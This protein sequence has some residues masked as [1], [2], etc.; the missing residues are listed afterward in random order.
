MKRRFWLGL[1]LAA[2][3]VH[4]EEVAKLVPYPEGYREWRF[5]G[6]I[7]SHPEERTDAP[8]GLIHHLYGNDQALEGLRTGIFPAGAVLVADW[9]LLKEKYSGSFDEGARD[10]TDVM[11]K[12]ARFAA[13]GGWGYDQFAGDSREIRRI[14]GAEPNQCSK[15]HT[16]VR[17][18]DYVFTSL[19]P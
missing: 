9:F 8:A 1:L 5:L 3:C 4:A 7:T 19:H 15:C 13:T 18:R 17:G 6:S 2:G 14:N 10:R 16:K 11:R 12:D